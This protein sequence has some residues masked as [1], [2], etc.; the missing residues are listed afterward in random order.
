MSQLLYLFAER[1]ALEQLLQL[2]LVAHALRQPLVVELERCCV[3]ID[4]P[5]QLPLQ[6][7]LAPRHLLLVM[8]SPILL[9]CGARAGE[10]P[11]RRAHQRAPQ[12]SREPPEEP[13]RL[14]LCRGLRLCR[15]L[16]LPPVADDPQRP[17][18]VVRRPLLHDARHIEHGGVAVGARVPVRD[19]K[20]VLHHVVR[21]VAALCACVCVGVGT[22]G[23]DAALARQL[24]S[25][26][27]PL[28]M[29]LLERPLRLHLD[30]LERHRCCLRL[31][32]PR[33]RR[34]RPAQHLLSNT[35]LCLPII[36]RHLICQKVCL[37]L[38][39]LWYL[40]CNRLVNVERRIERACRVGDDL[41]H[42]LLD[43]LERLRHL[44]QRPAGELRGLARQPSEGLGKYVLPEGVGAE[45]GDELVA[46]EQRV[47]R[48]VEDV[49]RFRAVDVAA[50]EL[51]AD[52]TV[53]EERDAAI[54]LQVL[55]AAERPFEAKEELARVV[56]E[57]V[58]LELATAALCILAARAELLEAGADHAAALRVDALVRRELSEVVPELLLDELIALRRHRVDDDVA[59][60]LPA[61]TAIHPVLGVTILHAHRL[62]RL[63]ADLLLDGLD[64]RLR[65]HALRTACAIARIRHQ[66]RVLA[67][68]VEADVLWRRAARAR[69]AAGA[70]LLLIVLHPASEA[71]ARVGED[72]LLDVLKDGFRRAAFRHDG[73]A[74]QA[75]VLHVPV[76][77]LDLEV[78][79]EDGVAKLCALIPSGRHHAL[80]CRELPGSHGLA[81]DRDLA[82]NDLVRALASRR[83]FR[84]RRDQ[85]EDVLNV[86]GH[87]R[88]RHAPRFLCPPQRSH[89]IRLRLEA[90]ALVPAREHREWQDPRRPVLLLVGYLHLLL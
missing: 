27:Q 11:S 53:D 32:G 71:A 58:D 39:E 7:L 38:L 28:V 77:I 45:E 56:L 87:S 36:R 82:A 9:R 90:P 89:V 60:M 24:V 19:G 79:A 1:L 16:P 61:V 31:A 10:V 54:E 22:E 63:S 14:L 88:W 35:I 81:S 30:D 25:E 17:V 20:L 59:Q 62:P 23:V 74:A 5:V 66:H 72:A 41:L 13:Y 55:A 65:Q 75:D 76:L 8:R 44:V 69:P 21:A 34:P 26:R 42:R 4:C 43:V 85:V 80:A 67:Q 18:K 40:V 86:V 49:L 51:E 3:L 15:R 29:Q 48:L 64:D 83:H 12:L 57:A 78:A 46:A 2:P 84:A 52:E 70:V 6:R 33:L 68:S 73:E 50:Q 47:Q 37:P